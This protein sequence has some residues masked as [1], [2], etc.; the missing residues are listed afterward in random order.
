M[1]DVAAGFLAIALLTFAGFVAGR[2]FQRTRVPDVLLLLGLGLMLGPVNRVLAGRGWGSDQLAAALDPAILRAA[3]PVLAGIALVVLVFDAGLQLDFG[4]F[5]KGLRPALLH[6][7]PIFFLTALGI[8]GVGVL[9]LGMPPLVAAILAVALTNVD[10]VVSSGVLRDLRIPDRQ[11]A[12]YTIEM[13][14]Y[15][16]VCIPLIVSLLAFADGT[17]TPAL[18]VRQFAVLL[19]V[20]LAVGLA[21][22]IPWLFALRTLS[23]HP[24]SY[25]LTFAT[26]IGVY[27]A[28]ELLGGSGALSILLFGILVG[29]RTAILRRFARVREDDHEHGKVV[30]F[31]DEITFLVRTMFFLFLGASFTFEGGLWPATPVAFFQGLSPGALFLAAAFLFL[32][33]I[34][35]ARYLSV[36]LASIRDPA[37]ADL[38][39]VF[40][41]GLDT[42]V[43]ATLPFVAPAYVPGS[44]FHDLF[45][46]WEAAFTNLSLLLVLLTVAASGLVVW[47]Q[48]RAQDRFEKESEMVVPAK[49]AAK[50][51]A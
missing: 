50:R 13:A 48:E 38:F 41:R 47:R 17:G 29:N 37:Q 24:H 49:P 36:R 34:V 3:T 22:G 46:P 28:S 9:L 4:P 18:F 15:D 10:Q 40:G 21:A 5:R 35:A 42:A 44:A 19:S 31:H 27:G 43:L 45:S 6:T 25:M 33:V 8:A 51:K 2:I 16:L 26:M 1:A 32:A 12:I 23:G 30:A 20:S 7:L 39:G 11:R 14:V